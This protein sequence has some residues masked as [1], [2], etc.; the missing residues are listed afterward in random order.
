MLHLLC[1]G[2]LMRT[3]FA[4]A[5]AKPRPP[6]IALGVNG[7]HF[8]QPNYYQGDTH[9]FDPLDPGAGCAHNGAG[10]SVASGV[11]VAAQLDEVQALA[12]NGGRGPIYYRH[13]IPCDTLNHCPAKRT[14][15]TAFVK[16]AKARIAMGG[17][18]LSYF[19]KCPHPSARTQR[20]T[21]S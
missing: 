17:A 9:Y 7:H 2:A 14:A 15:A 1:A 4:E 5:P 19:Y 12:P 10:G 21:W 6:T 16:A 3:A 18:S 11:S 20:Y 8:T 13:D